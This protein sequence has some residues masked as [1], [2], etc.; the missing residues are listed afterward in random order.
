MLK[1]SFTV[2]RLDMR[3]RFGLIVEAFDDVLMPAKRERKVIV[4]GRDGAHDY[5]AKYYDERVIT[6]ACASPRLSRSECRALADILTRR[7]AIV[8]WDEPDKYYMG[9]VYDA[10]EIERLAGMAKRFEIVY[11]CD[12]FAYGETVSGPMPVKMDYK[13]T[14]MT[15]T[16]IEIRNTSDKT[17]QGVMIQIRERS[18]L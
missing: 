18:D 3:E 8:R 13:G 4:P 17:L 15:P 7:S 16:R 9:Q 10:T 14:A 5:G 6:I 11:T 1:Y 2:N 12:P